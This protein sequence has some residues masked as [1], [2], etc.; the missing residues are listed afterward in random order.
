MVAATLEAWSDSDDGRSVT[1]NSK[2]NSKTSSRNNSRSNSRDGSR[3]G[4]VSEGCGGDCVCGGSGALPRDVKP[5]RDCPVV[6]E[7]DSARQKQMCNLIC[8]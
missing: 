2:S 6:S 3:A 5:I 1:V 4:S 7:F 8:F